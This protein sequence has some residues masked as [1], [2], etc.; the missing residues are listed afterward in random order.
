VCVCVCV[1]VCACVFKA[2]VPSR[3]QEVRVKGRLWLV[4]YT[5]KW[6]TTC[7]AV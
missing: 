3:Y 1:C 5:V 6:R 2:Q 4:N 7:Q